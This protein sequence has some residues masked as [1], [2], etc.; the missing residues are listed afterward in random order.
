MSRPTRFFDFLNSTYT[1]TEKIQ[2]VR[3][4]DQ[5]LFRLS[6][7]VTEGFSAVKGLDLQTFHRHKDLGPSGMENGN[8]EPGNEGRTARRRRQEEF[9]AA[10]ARPVLR[11]TV[12]PF[13]ACSRARR[14]IGFAPFATR[15][16]LAEG[17]HGPALSILRKDPADRSSGQPRAQRHQPQVALELENGSRGRGWSHSPG[18]RLHTVHS[19]GKAG[20][21]GRPNSLSGDRLTVVGD[22]VRPLRPEHGC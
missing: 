9:P 6:A 15:M 3:G 21:A 16:G 7:K 10:P 14:E 12:F 11:L 4:F 1:P 20:Q 18:S 2:T 22:P 13:P 17:S 8:R 19:V 5:E